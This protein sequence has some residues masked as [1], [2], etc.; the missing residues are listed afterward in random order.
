MT[1]KN[2][3][4][5]IAARREICNLPDDP[6]VEDWEVGF[7]DGQLLPHGASR[8]LM[9]AVADGDQENIR[10]QLLQVPE[11]KR[12]ELIQIIQRMASIIGSTR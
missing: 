10:A 2:D 3:D 8:E 1:D 6:N 12:A 9:I 4:P 11:P 5:L 7:V